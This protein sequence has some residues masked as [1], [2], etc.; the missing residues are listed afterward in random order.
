MA[1]TPLPT[2]LYVCLSIDSFDTIFKNDV[3]HLKCC[4]FFALRDDLQENLFDSECGED[5]V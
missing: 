3:L 2:R 1:R 5:G 4:A